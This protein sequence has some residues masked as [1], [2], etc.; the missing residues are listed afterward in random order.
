MVCDGVAKSAWT[1]DFAQ[2]V[3]GSYNGI[4]LAVVGERTLQASDHGHESDGRINGQEDV[5]EDDEGE[6]GARLGNP[7][8]LVP[9][10]A[11]VPIDVGDCDGVDGGDD[12]GDL[13]R[14]RGLIDVCWDGKWIR[15]GG[16]A[17]P[18][19][20]EWRRRSV[21]RE[22]EDSCRGPVAWVQ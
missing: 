12:Q 22:F 5:V 11:I 1:V 18:L 8:R 13:V 7:P 2:S 14:Q 20:R 17:M 4:G 3:D 16:L 19:G 21:G 6:E 10:L 15:E 9:M